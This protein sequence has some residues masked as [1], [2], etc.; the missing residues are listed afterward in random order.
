[1]FYRFFSKEQ[2]SDLVIIAQAI[3][4]KMPLISDD[5]KFPPY[6]SEGLELIEN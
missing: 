3:T 4:M 2:P 1:M 5:K 6:R